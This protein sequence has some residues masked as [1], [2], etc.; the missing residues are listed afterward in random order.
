MSR[1]VIFVGLFFLSVLLLS[2]TYMVVL[3]PFCIVMFQAFDGKVGILTFQ[4][5]KQDREEK[6]FSCCF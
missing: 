4:V 2:L 5:V 1:Y 3:V 6:F